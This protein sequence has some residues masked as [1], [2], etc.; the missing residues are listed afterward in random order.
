MTGCTSGHILTPASTSSPIADMA[1]SSMRT[2]LCDSAVRIQSCFGTDNGSSVCRAVARFRV[3][4]SGAAPAML[5][6]TAGRRW[7]SR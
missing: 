5:S 3:A 2:R 7:D 4:S 6:S 1:L